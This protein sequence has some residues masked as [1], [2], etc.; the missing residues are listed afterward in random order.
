MRTASKTNTSSMYK[1]IGHFFQ[2]KRKTSGYSQKVAA[3]HLGVHAQYLSNVERGLCP[4]SNVHKKRL[5]K[6]YKINAHEFL[7]FMLTQQET[8]LRS[9]FNIRRKRG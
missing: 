6:F 5:L 9:E 3:N 2:Q 1:K 7:D 4:L 8:F